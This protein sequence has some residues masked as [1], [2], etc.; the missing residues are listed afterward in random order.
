M[1]KKSLILSGFAVIMGVFGAFLRWL[2][3]TNTYDA[4]THLFTS[5]SPW[6]YAVALFAVLFVA[7]LLV[8][9]NKQKQLHFDSAFPEVYSNTIPFVSIAAYIIGALVA[10]GGILTIYRSVIISKSAFDLILGFFSFVSA[11]GLISFLVSVGKPNKGGKSG[12]FGAVSTVFFLCFWLIASYKSSADEPAIWYFAPRLLSIC[13]T[14]LAFYF[15][16]GF[17][18]NKPKP[19]AALYF[20]LL[21][22][23]LCVAV[24]ADNYPLGEQLMTFGFAAAMTIL[25]FSQVNSAKID[26]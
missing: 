25:S 19:L 22:T 4:E 3:N 10:A 20:N 2:Q 1:R 12:V 9:V 13:A 18:F 16:A 6:N 7:L 11:A 24:L 26:N 21:G 17:V 23:F 15:N 5:H 8:W 14:I